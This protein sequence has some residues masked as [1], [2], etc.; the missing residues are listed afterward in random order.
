LKPSPPDG[1]VRRA[2]SR[3]P[4]NRHSGNIAIVHC[5]D[6]EDNIDSKSTFIVN[7]DDFTP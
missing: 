6:R 2:F 3:P 1:N 4:E 5:D 7:D